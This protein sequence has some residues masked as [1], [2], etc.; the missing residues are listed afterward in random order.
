MKTDQ[1]APE[2]PLAAS[3]AA[4]EA[5]VPRRRPSNPSAPGKIDEL[6]DA[7][8]AAM[9]S[10]AAELNI[11]GVAVV[12]YAPGDQHPGLTSKMAVVAA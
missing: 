8:L 6:T 12:A 4:G 5:A 2:M 10:R 11:T 1:P 3:A 7:A 9:K